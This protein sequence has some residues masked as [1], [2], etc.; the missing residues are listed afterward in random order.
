MTIL[1]NNFFSDLQ[2]NESRYVKEKLY[3]FKEILPRICNM[4][5]RRIVK[6]FDINLND[7]PLDEPDLF[8]FVAKTTSEGIPE[9]YGVIYNGKEYYQRLVVTTNGDNV[10]SQK[11][12]ENFSELV[13]AITDKK[14]KFLQETLSEIFEKINFEYIKGA[15]RAFKANGRFN[16]MFGILK[17]DR[18]THITVY[19]IE[20]TDYSNTVDRYFYD[21]CK[22]NGMGNNTDN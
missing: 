19:E 5:N 16:D 11:I 13:Y 18:K 9:F 7:N 22:C 4:V 1:N 17:D 14:F 8:K 10:V 2:R 3:F 21:C 12:E 6:E 15:E 20:N